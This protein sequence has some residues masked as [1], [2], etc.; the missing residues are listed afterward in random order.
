V[1]FIGLS[2]VPC[3]VFFIPFQR[4][5]ST[6]VLKKNTKVHGAETKT[7]TYLA[8]GIRSATTKPAIES[9]MPVLARSE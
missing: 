8:T 6:L 5:H 2:I 7:P 9:F 4:T 3:Q 1:D